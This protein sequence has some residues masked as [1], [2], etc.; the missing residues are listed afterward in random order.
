LYGQGSVPA[1]LT[2]ALAVSAGSYHNLALL[3]TPTAGAALPAPVRIG[4]QVRFSIPTRRGQVSILEYKA[5]LDD[6]T[7]HW[8][9][10]MVGDGTTRTLTDSPGNASMRFY[11]LHYP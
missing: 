4:Q 8:V 9:A 2:K 11:R 5:S 7:W 1:G 6:P 10:A 3:G